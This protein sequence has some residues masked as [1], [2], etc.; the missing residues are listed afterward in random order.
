MSLQTWQETLISSQID[1]TAHGN[2]TSKSAT[3]ILVPAAAKLTFPAAFFQIGR[4]IRVKAAGRVSNI[5]TT[6]GTLTFTLET[7]S[8]VLANSGAIT[9]NTTAKTNVSWML[10]WLLTCR[11]IGASANFMHQGMWTSESVVSS[12][13]G[14]AGAFMLPASAPAVG[15]NFDSTQANTME[16][17][18]QWSI[19]N[20]G[21][22]LQCHQYFVE[23]L[24]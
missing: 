7:A 1:G 14:T 19:A 5:V 15:A 18:A 16:L 12:P 6:P 17:F 20:A 13:A 3:G 10:E 11:A 21:N 24:N 2:S 22:T 23:L 8:V 4:V 9:L